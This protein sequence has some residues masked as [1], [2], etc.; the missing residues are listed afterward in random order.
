V[1][2]SLVVEAEL[3]LRARVASAEAVVTVP[4]PG[5]CL[6]RPGRGE[7]RPLDPGATMDVLRAAPPGA[8]ALARAASADP[9]AAVLPAL[10]ALA[11]LTVVTLPEPADAAVWTVAVAA[12]WAAEGVDD[13]LRAIVVVCGL[14]DREGLLPRRRWG[15]A[16]LRAPAV[17]PRALARW[18]TRAW[19]PCSWC[20]RGGG[21]ASACCGLCGAAVLGARA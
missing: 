19:R 12:H 17:R 11:G 15:A 1:S 3:A 20:R 7:C 13:L 8:L 2:G 10:A 4:R 9:G 18:A 6:R 5:R 14:W 16:D 21:L